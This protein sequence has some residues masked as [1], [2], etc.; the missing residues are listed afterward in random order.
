MVGVCVTLNLGIP[1]HV[2][3]RQKI[4]SEA[5][6]QRRVMAKM[7]QHHSLAFT[8]SC[9]GTFTL[10]KNEKRLHTSGVDDFN[11]RLFTCQSDHFEVFLISLCK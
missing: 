3:E 9:R 10:S 8:T 5:P 11:F 2:R 4:A 7:L 6:W 1:S